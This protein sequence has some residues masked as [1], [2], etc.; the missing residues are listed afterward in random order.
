MSSC[1]VVLISR[2]IHRGSPCPDEVLVSICIAPI[3]RPCCAV[4]PCL[5]CC[6]ALVLLQLVGVAECVY[7]AVC[8]EC[9]ILCRCVLL[10]RRVV[11]ICQGNTR[12]RQLNQIRAY[13]YAAV[14]L[15]NQNLGRIALE[16]LTYNKLSVCSSLSRIE[17]DCRAISRDV[18]ALAHVHYSQGECHIGC[19]VVSE[20]GCSACGHACTHCG[21]CQCRNNLLHNN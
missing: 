17:C 6:T 14:N 7:E 21:S 13:S 1:G 16:V 2:V 4:A 10:S 5:N 12:I 20:Y 8:G 3:C 15:L 9:N 11:G 19:V 18:V